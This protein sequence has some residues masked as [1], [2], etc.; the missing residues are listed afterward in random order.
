[1]AGQTAVLR[2]DEAAAK[3]AIAQILEVGWGDSFRAIEPA[4]EHFEQAKGAAPR[5]PRVAFAFALVHIKHGRHSDAVKLLDEALSLDRRHVPAREAK[6]WIDVLL[7]RY[8][9]ALV[10]IDELA[11]LLPAKDTPGVSD[12]VKARDRDTARFIG[13]LF[14]FFE[15]PAEKSINAVRLAEAKKGVLE[16]LSAEHREEFEAGRKAV[17]DRFAEFFLM[18]EQT[19]DDEA[20]AQK[21]AKDEEARR[22]AEDKAAVAADKATVAKQATQTREQLDKFLSDVDRQLAPLD[23]E[24]ARLSAQGVGL[25]ERMIDLDRDISRLLRLAETTEDRATAARYRLDAQRVQDI[26]ARHAADYRVLEAQAGRVRGQ[27]AALLNERDTAVARY[28][29]EAKRL[30]REQV[31]LAQTE[32]RIARDEDRNRMPPSGNTDKVH[33]LSQKV[34]AFTTYEPFPLERARSRLVESLR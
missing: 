19:K 26:R 5:D 32:K 14:G 33:V 22:L 29:A 10:Q 13:R 2:A 25:R 12:E 16:R 11:A 6:I 15:G 1:L 9:A 18:R 21:K 17:S 3:R 34:L 27:Q 20:A 28:N 4:R 23:K 7:K 30:G 31:K 24:Y 8:P